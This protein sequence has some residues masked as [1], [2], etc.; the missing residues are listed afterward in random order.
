[1]KMKKN[2]NTIT[3]QWDRDAGTQTSKASSTHCRRS[4][5]NIVVIFHNHFLP[6]TI[7]TSVDKP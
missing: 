5:R 4:Q 1:M 3:E 6:A 2:S 7:V